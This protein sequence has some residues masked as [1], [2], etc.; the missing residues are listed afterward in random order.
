MK[1]ILIVDDDKPLLEAMQIAV[2]MQGYDVK[3]VSN[4]L[5]V[6]SVVDDYS[7]DL[8]LLDV[9]LSGLDGRDIAKSLKNKSETKDI[10]LVMLS[11]SPSIEETVKEVGADGF[12]AKPFE[13]S[14]LWEIVNKYASQTRKNPVK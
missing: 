10:P 8:I 7:P 13:L 5:E 2:E 6:T 3:T 14:D 11:A 1:K 12:V 4:A 9:L